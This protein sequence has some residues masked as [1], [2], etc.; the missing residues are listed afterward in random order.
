MANEFKIKNALLVEGSTNSQSIIAIRNASTDISADA[1]SLLPTSKA[2]YDFVDSE[3]LPIEASLNNVVDG[4]S[5]FVRSSSIGSSSAHT[6]YFDN[7]Y[8]ESSTGVAGAQGT[9]G[10]QGAIGSQGA[11]GAQGVQGAQGTVGLL[12]DDSVNEIYAYFVPNGSIGDSATHTVFWENGYLEASVGSGGGG[13]GDVA[14]ASGAV[15]SN[16]QLLTAYGDGS[17][18]AESNLLFDGT[19]MVVGASSINSGARTLEVIGGLDVS[20]G[21]IHLD[22]NNNFWFGPNTD[23]GLRMAMK[24]VTATGDAYLDYYKD[25]HFRSGVSSSADKII[26]TTNGD[27]SIASDANKSIA[28]MPSDTVRT[29]SIIGNSPISGGSSGGHIA[30]FGGNTPGAYGGDVSIRGGDGGSGAGDI[31]IEGG[32]AGGGGG[33]IWIKGGYSSGAAGGNITIA[34]GDWGSGNAG[35]ISIGAFDTYKIYIGNPGGPTTYTGNIVAGPATITSNTSHASGNAIYGFTDDTTKGI[36]GSGTGPSGIVE[37][38]I[39]AGAKL[40]VASGGTYIAN[41]LSIGDDIF[42]NGMDASVKD[43]V[44]YYDTTSKQLTYGAV[45]AG[46]DI[47]T[48]NIQSYVNTSTYY[49]GSLMYQRMPNPS[50]GLSNSTAQGAYVNLVAGESITANYA[51]CIRPDGKAYHAR[52]NASDYMPA[53]ALNT[54]GGTVSS[55]SSADFLVHG[56]AKVGSGT[57]FQAGKQVYVYDGINGYIYYSKPTAANSCVQVVGIAISRESLIW[58]PSPDFIVLK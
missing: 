10:S 35:D 46:G 4:Y 27:V 36:G 13:T 44:V 34:A 31:Y 50:T 28:M 26:I 16:N 55:G 33:N 38:I 57:Y 37:I 14:W 20:G 23:A 48:L 40:K 7:G 21:S 2:V 12:N 24:V 30:I 19:R 54:T 3:L 1:S 8:L 53:V 29:L 39:D 15:G 25:L 42:V 41:D 58:N 45:P 9:A 51:V 32:I 52:A 17:I 43:N 22:Y 47:S 6:V 18:V 11:T 49:D 56:V 5:I